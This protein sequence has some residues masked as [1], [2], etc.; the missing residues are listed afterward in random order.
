MLSH[1]RHRDALRLWLVFIPKVELISVFPTVMMPLALGDGRVAPTPNLQ[2]RLYFSASF[3]M[4]RCHAIGS[5]G[6]QLSLSR[7]LVVFGSSSDMAATQNSGS[8]WTS[9]DLL[10]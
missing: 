3:V 10:T 6:Y 7:S 1:Y 5:A 2:G 9:G 4:F 8:D